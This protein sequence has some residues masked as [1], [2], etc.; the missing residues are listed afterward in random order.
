MYIDCPQN[1]FLY[2]SAR[3]FIENFL[4]KKSNAKFKQL[5]SNI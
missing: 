2:A 1:R 4:K 3:R 5:F